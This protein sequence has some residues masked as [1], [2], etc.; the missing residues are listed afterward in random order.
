MEMIRNN[1]FSF[2]RLFM[3]LKREWANNRQKMLL[4]SGVMAGLML[5]VYF[6]IIVTA[7]DNRILHETFD[8]GARILIFIMLF[9]FSLGGCISASLMNH[10]YATKSGKIDAM[11]S[12]GTPLEKYLVRVI[13]YIFGY[14]LLFFVSLFILEFLRIEYISSSMP[15]YNVKSLIN[16]ITEDPILNIRLYAITSVCLP[17]AS[18]IFYVGFFALM[19]SI[20]PKYSFLKGYVVITAISTLVIIAINTFFKY[21]MDEMYTETYQVEIWLAFVC[22]VLAVF[23]PIM[24]VIAYYRYKE[25]DLQ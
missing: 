21:N 19:S 11:M 22:I 7:Y 8:M 9:F 4:Q 6:L 16:V 24:N 10:N 23:G 17:I 3:L 13:F 25:T 14:I 18:Y 20:T 15:W 1:S 5:L 2:V 12:V